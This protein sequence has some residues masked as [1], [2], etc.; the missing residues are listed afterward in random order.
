MII[1]VGRNRNELKIILKSIMYSNKFNLQIL[2]F[3]FVQK[4]NFRHM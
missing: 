2:C 1:A 4:L 3:R